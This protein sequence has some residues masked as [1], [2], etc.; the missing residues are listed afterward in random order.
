MTQSS[1]SRRYRIRVSVTL[2][3]GMRELLREAFEFESQQVERSAILN[4]GKTKYFTK[5]QARLRTDAALSARIGQV[6]YRVRAADVQA[7]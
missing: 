5:L 4:D 3:T 2:A 1:Q 6:R 7:L